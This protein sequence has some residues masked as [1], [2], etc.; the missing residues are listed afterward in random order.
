MPLPKAAARK[1]AHTRVIDCKGYERED[2]LWD[3]EGHL[4]DVKAYTWKNRGSGKDVAAGEPTHDM[5]LRIT[6]DLELRIHDAVAVTDSGPFQPCGDIT[7]K[8]AA[9]KG[10]RIGRG[11]LKD[12]RDVIG[13]AQGCTHHWELLGRVATVAYQTTHLARRTLPRKPGEIPHLFN[14][15]HMY[16]AGSVETQH[17][18]PDLYQPAKTTENATDR[19]A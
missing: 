13:G 9:L 18:W 16:A 4:T 11:W 6:I 19:S 3:I 8:F 5:Y 2:G 7:P 12:L 1:L 15:C 17:R 10:K 14:T